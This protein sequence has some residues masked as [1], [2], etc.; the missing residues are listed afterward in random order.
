MCPPP[1]RPAPYRPTPYRPSFPPPRRSPRLNGWAVAG[2]VAVV[3][4]S[5]VFGVVH[6]IVTGNWADTPGPQ[7]A[8]HHAPQGHFAAP[9]PEPTAVSRPAAFRARVVSYL[10][11]NP[12]DLSV[13]IRVTNTG[14]EAGTPECVIN[15]S[16]PSGT[17][18]GF[19]EA[20]MK[21]SLGGGRSATFT[22]N[23]LVITSQGSAYVT[24]VTVQCEGS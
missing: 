21:G 7:P 17:Y 23:G 20:V 18:H 4:A 16:D 15:A 3:G 5:V 10:E 24:S 8:A 14:T 9:V 12:A 6:G 13:T 1:Y 22:D 2:I 19:D 11:I